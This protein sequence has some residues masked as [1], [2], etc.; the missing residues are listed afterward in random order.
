MPLFFFSLF[1]PLDARWS[2][3]L[4]GKLVGG[5]VD[6]KDKRQ[7]RISLHAERPGSARRQERPP[8]KASFSGSAMLRRRTNT[9]RLPWNGKGVKKA[10][11][12]PASSPPA[13]NVVLD[14]KTQPGYSTIAYVEHRGLAN[15]RLCNL[16]ETTQRTG[17][18]FQTDEP[19]T[20]SDRLAWPTTRHGRRSGNSTLAKVLGGQPNSTGASRVLS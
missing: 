6:L 17:H 15:G 1:Q 16:P 4:A 7:S 2:G 18:P 11:S 8:H 20:R 13:N 12:F 10:S 5:P 9:A 3:N 14:S 19:N